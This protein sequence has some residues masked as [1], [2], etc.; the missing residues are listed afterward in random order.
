M[1]NGKLVYDLFLKLT[2]EP[3]K[4]IPEVLK[5][6]EEDYLPYELLEANYKKYLEN[7]YIEIIRDYIKNSSLWEK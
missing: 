7:I 4:D 6:I 5:E 2:L 3:F 1:I